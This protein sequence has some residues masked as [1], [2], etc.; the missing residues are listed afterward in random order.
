MDRRA[1]LKTTGAAAA[2]ATSAAS[3][4][5]VSASAAL[6]SPAAVSG[7]RD[8]TLG[9]PWPDNGQGFGDSGRRLARRIEAV[10]EGRV[11]VAIS[12]SSKSSPDGFDLVHG[13]AHD[14]ASAHPAFA[15]FA[16]LPGKA[17]LGARDLEAWL[18]VGGGQALWDELA[19]D[20]GWKPLLAGHSGAAP[21]IWS[22]RPWRA[23]SEFS[24]A[25]VFA[26]GLGADVARALGAEPVSLSISEIVS[27]LS[28]ESLQFAEWGGALQSLA[29][30]FHKPATHATG[31]GLNGFGTALSLSV[32]LPVWDSLTESDRSRLSSAVAEEFRDSVNEAQAHEAVVRE[33]LANTYGVKFPSFTDEIGAAISR[34][35]DATVAHLSAF[36]VRSARID[37]SYMAFRSTTSDETRSQL[38]S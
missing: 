24:G 29:A 20:A 25:R 13:T 19:L 34:V 9:M 2:A 37:R 26:V 4:S 23:L 14:W 28:A 6:A 31:S 18:A 11:R 32:R 1:F 12:E 36:D 8:L 16:G 33:V 3:A 22:K 21:A 38:T 30:G 35:A 5:V 7:I 17:G 15:Y 10:F 27:G